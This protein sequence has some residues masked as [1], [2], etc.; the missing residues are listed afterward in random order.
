M[1]TEHA[2]IR[3]NKELVTLYYV[4]DKEKTTDSGIIYNSS[5]QEDLHLAVVVRVGKD[6]PLDVK[7][8]DTVYYDGKIHGQIDDLYFVHHEHICMVVND[9]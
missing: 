8:G 7:T 5:G 1:N 9:D 3:P 4:D 2:K 6:V